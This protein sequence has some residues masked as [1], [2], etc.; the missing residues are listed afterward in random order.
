M[1][2]TM[3]IRIGLISDTHSTV[4]PLRE[5]LDIFKREDVA[6]IICAGD[7]VGY[8][9]DKPEET[10]ALL[11]EHDCLMVVGNHDYMP[12]TVQGAAAKESIQTFF[13][14]LPKKIE[15]TV[16]GKRIY[17]VHA[18]PPDEQYGGI[19]ILDPE[20]K[21]VEEKKNSWT[22]QLESLVSDVLIIGHTHQ[23]FAEY[24]GKLLVINPGSTCFNHTCMLLTLPEMTVETFSLSGKQP[25][26]V[27][28]W[29]IFFQEQADSLRNSKLE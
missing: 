23:V 20:G 14:S 21:V 27:W 8:G 29:G 5:A 7:I 4:A 12:D 19:K 6:R 16:E 10:I 1:V 13:D 11:Q 15:L 3:S 24:F 17:V 26:M 25:V 9:E 2:R 28:N 18:H 22:N